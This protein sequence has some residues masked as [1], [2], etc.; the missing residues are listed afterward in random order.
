VFTSKKQKQCRVHCLSFALPSAQNR[1]KAS[2]FSLIE[3]VLALGII[4]M[5]FVPLMGLLPVGLSNFRGSIDQ[6]VVAQ[7]VQRL[8]NEAQQSDFESVTAYAG[9][10]FD[11]QA[12]EVDASESATYVARLLVMRDETY[13]KRLI[14]Q[15]ARNPGGAATLREESTGGGQNLWSEANAL[16]VFT[17]S[18]LLACSSGNSAN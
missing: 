3:V 17:R 9:R 10:Y 7:I 18:L 5:A 8:G 11:D 13:L 1:N 16:P 14:V 4:A 12:R 6:T 2:A 15:V